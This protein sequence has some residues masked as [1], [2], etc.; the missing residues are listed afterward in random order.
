MRSARLALFIAISCCCTSS[1]W[2]QNI[3]AWTDAY[4]RNLG[5]TKHFRGVVLAERAGE[6]LV[7]ESFGLASE[8]W[9]AP[10][11]VD[12]DFELASLTKQFTAVAIL[13]LVDAGKL[14]L[15]DPLTKYFASAPATWKGITIHH[16][17]THTSGLPNNGLE[18]YTKGLCV[19]YTPEEL[20]G[21]FRDR[22]ALSYLRRGLSPGG[23]QRL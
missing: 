11:A 15:D 13:Q 6:I 14:G 9:Q 1:C 8:E 23:A 21:T 17:L 20:I 19:P 22:P 16:L 10:N 2:P 3:R 18:H 5:P 12:T 4:V 7:E